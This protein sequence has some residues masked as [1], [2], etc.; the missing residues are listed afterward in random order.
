ME[1]EIWREGENGEIERM[2]E[3][4]Q[5]S[6]VT[7]GKEKLAQLDKWSACTTVV[8]TLRCQCASCF[9]ISFELS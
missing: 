5:H 6:Q 2:A 9:F 4:Q 8:S 7:T 1:S 3:R